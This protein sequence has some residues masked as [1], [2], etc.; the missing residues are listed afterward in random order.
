MSLTDDAIQIRNQADALR[1]RIKAIIKSLPDYAP[2]ATPLGSGCFT[3]PY[4]MLRGSLS[5][6]S[7]A[8]KGWKDVLIKD[9][10][11]K[12]VQGLLPLL[13]EMRDTGKYKGRCLPEAFLNS[14]RNALSENL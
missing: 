8:F 3:V 6:S 2:E 5:P 7:F 14:L 11:K 9:I 10:D 4:G 13:E 12:D 1:A